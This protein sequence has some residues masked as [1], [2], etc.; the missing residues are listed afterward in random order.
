[1]RPFL[2]LFRFVL[3]LLFR[4]CFN[5]FFF[6]HSNIHLLLLPPLKNIT[7]LPLH[8]PLPNGQRLWY[9]TFKNTIKNTFL[10]C[11]PPII[12][13]SLTPCSFFLL[14]PPPYSPPLSLPPSPPC[15]SLFFLGMAECTNV[16]GS[17]VTTYEHHNIIHL[18][19][20]LLSQGVVKEIDASNPA[21]LLFL[22]FLFFLSLLF[23]SSPTPTNTNF[24][25]IIYL[26]LH[27]IAKTL[28][29]AA[30]KTW[31]NCFDDY[32]HDNFKIVGEDGQELE[33]GEVG[34]VSFF[35]FFFSLFISSFS[36]LFSLF[37]F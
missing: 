20:D 3:L 33:D 27:T 32:P 35:F 37:F 5:F 31:P 34:E 7:D 29:A 15:L 17:A 4:H 16:L 28:L 18:D 2:V 23:L 1:M 24:I 30:R 36:F 6:L 21:G 13:P 9:V 14:L 8:P 10:S 11:S 25:M 12:P 22:I 26:F 19:R